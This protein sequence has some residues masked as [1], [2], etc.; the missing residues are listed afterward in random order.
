VAEAIEAIGRMPLPP[1]IRRKA[2]ELDKE[3]YQ[4]VFASKQGAVAAP[5]AGLHFTTELIEDIIEMGVEVHYITLHTGP[6]TFMPVRTNDIRGHRLP[7]EYFNIKPSVF[8]AVKCAREQRRRVI[9]SGSTAT[10]ALETAFNYGF[11]GARLEGETELF[12]YPGFEFKVI[13][14]LLT[15][16]HLP[17]SSLIMLVS[18]FAGR[19]NVMEAYRE[20]IKQRYRFYSYGDAMLI[21]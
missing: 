11:S 13:N 10:R 6:A 14:G 7:H 20:A 3:R 17:G 9:A 21:I 2:A 16:F 1:Y 5:T 18:A 4:T 8:E 15:N 19:D 12:I